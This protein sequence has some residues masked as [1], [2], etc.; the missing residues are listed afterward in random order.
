MKRRRLL[1]NGIRIALSLAALYILFREVGGRKVFAS[2]SSANYGLLV[3]AFL[4]FLTGVVIRVFRWRA[5]LNGLELRPPFGLLL[6]LYL[7]GGFFNAFL[8]SGFGGDV[9]RVLELGRAGRRSAADRSAA[10]GTVFVDRLTGLL[11]LMALGLI[12]LPFAPGLTAWHRWAFVAISAGGL[13]AG[14]LLLEGNLLRRLTGRLPRSISLAGEGKLAQV[15]AAISGSGTRAIA[16]A[17]L[18]S[19]LFNLLN[20]ILHWLCARAVGIELGLV[21]YFAIVPLLSL[22]LLIPLP[23]GLGARDWTGQLLLVPLGVAQSSIA[24]WTLSVWAVSAAVGL[25]GGLI[26]LVQSLSDLGR[27]ATGEPRHPSAATDGVSRE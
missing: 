3:A 23:G 17:L 21:A 22:A 13:L 27:S 10:L 1:S 19:T 18:Y 14:A 11:S 7:V 9:V 6:K 15:Y 2:L 12:V 16:W 25:I 8:P 4:L 24:A 26:Y 5:L 20:I